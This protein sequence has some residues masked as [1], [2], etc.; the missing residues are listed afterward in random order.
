MDGLDGAILLKYV[1]PGLTELTNSGS[2]A[3]Y[4][5]AGGQLKVNHHF[6]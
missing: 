5:V 2:A 6:Q 4:L 1:P 3:R